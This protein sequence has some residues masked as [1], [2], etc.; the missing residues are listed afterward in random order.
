MV[1][2]GT[3]RGAEGTREERE[4]CEGSGRIV[5]MYHCDSCTFSASELHLRCNMILNSPGPPPTKHFRH[6]PSS[7]YPK[8]LL[9]LDALL[10]QIWLVFKDTAQAQTLT[11]LAAVCNA[12]ILSSGLNGDLSAA[13]REVVAAFASNLMDSILQH[14]LVLDVER[15][16]PMLG[17]D[18]SGELGEH[19]VVVDFLARYAVCGT[20][21]VVYEEGPG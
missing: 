15:G 5:R 2:R 1:S 14:D 7:F 18:C 17:V 16:R 20:G 4:A 3:S 9:M 8:F 13:A 6:A 10:R 11:V 12:T 21:V 19:A